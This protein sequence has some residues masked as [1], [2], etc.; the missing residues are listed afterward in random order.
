MRLHTLRFNVHFDP[1]LAIRHE[2][3]DNEAIREGDCVWL[4][5]DIKLW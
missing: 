2:R 1:T 4:V 3:D 5:V